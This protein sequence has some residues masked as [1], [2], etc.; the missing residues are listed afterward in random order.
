MEDYQA[1]N[2]KRD[3]ILTGIA[4]GLILYILLAVKVMAEPVSDEDM[5]L[6]AKTVWLESGNQDLEGRRLVAA[7]I[8]NRVESSEFP[9]TVEEVLS[10]ENQF[11]TY[12][13]LSEATP[14][15]RDL[16]ATKMEIENRSDTD[17]LFFR[18]ER[19][20]CGVPLY[21]HGDHYFSTLAD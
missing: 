14:T 5:E 18:T 2:K 17:V 11:S 6:I 21:K 19:Y 20:G 16:L 9:D 7:T 8:L 1:M 3:E 12:P 13:R 15:W 10:Q 4:I